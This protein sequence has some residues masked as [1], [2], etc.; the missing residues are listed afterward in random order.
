MFEH[1]AWIFELTLNTKELSGL[2][3]LMN[4][5]VNATKENEPG[6]LAYEWTVSEDGE[7]CHIY[8]CYESDEATLAHLATFKEKYAAR[9]MAFGDATSFVVYGSP[10]AAVIGALDG[11]GAKYMAPIGG[12]RR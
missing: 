5:M 11:F 4:K 7:I 3:E 12:F 1:I 8:E 9:L 10:N 6:T 2:K